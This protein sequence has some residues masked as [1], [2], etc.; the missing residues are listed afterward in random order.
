MRT[1]RI[2]VHWRRKFIIFGCAAVLTGCQILP[3]TFTQTP[4]P[5]IALATATPAAGDA[6]TD[7][8]RI[9]QVW[10]EAGSFRM[11]TDVETID[12]LHKLNPPPF[13]TG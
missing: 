6:R 13:V 4:I 3:G 8:K 1:I 11:G 7:A 12:A 2:Q 10:V 9:E 5:T